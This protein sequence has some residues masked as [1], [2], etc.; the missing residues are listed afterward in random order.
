MDS[1][2][3]FVY[4]EF[5]KNLLNWLKLTYGLL[6]LPVSL[7]WLLQV[8]TFFPVLAQEGREYK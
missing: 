8:F 4:A 2:T 5:L 3:A 6:S 7:C 1:S